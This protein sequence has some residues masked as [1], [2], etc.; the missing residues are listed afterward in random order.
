MS[1]CLRDAVTKDLVRNLIFEDFSVFER[2]GF[3]KWIA[4]LNPAYIPPSRHTAAEVA[5]EIADECLTR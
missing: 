5:D 2:P 1:K 4:R 3:Q